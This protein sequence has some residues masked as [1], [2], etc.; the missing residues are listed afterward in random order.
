MNTRTSDGACARYDICAGP[1]GQLWFWGNCLGQLLGKL[2]CWDNSMGQL[3]LS[4]G[5]VLGQV[6][7]SSVRKSLPLG[8]L[9]DFPGQVFPLWGQLFGRGGQLVVP[10]GQLAF[11]LRQFAFPS[12]RLNCALRPAGLC[13][14]MS[15]RAQSS[16]IA[17]Q[18]QFRRR[19]REQAGAGGGERKGRF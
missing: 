19:R 14:F 18:R 16:R 11:P 7:F 10:L 5:H 1:R 4:L 3:S 13:T 17:C 12:G 6:L 8:R 15:S 2:W 9:K